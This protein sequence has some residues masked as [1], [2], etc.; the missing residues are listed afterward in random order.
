VHGVTELVDAI[1]QLLERSRSVLR[2]SA[3]WNA[4]YEIIHA[5]LALGPE[6][7]IRDAENSRDIT[8]AEYFCRGGPYLGQP[9]YAENQG[10]VWFA[11]GK[12]LVEIETHPNQFL[13]YFAQMGL[14]RDFP[15]QT[16][17]KTFTI[18][19]LVATAK[20]QFDPA[21]DATWTL[22]TLLEYGDA[23]EKWSNQF[24]QVFQ[25]TDL[26]PSVVAEL[27]GTQRVCGGTHA[28]LALAISRRRLASNE[29][30]SEAVLQVISS[31][32][33]TELQDVRQSQASDGG[34]AASWAADVTQDELGAKL[35]ATG[36]CLEWILLTLPP[37]ELSSPWVV[38]AVGFLADALSSTNDGSRR[39]PAHYHALHALRMYKETVST[40]ALCGTTRGDI[41][42]WN[43]N[44]LWS[45]QP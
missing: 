30:S 10:D 39:V 21:E 7:V 32:L 40:Y 24:G 38:R 11:R 14:P 45:F 26:V 19:D 35:Y 31:R 44:S 1:S 25:V 6:A 18:A 42:R 43:S 15:I 5:G 33:N 2:L 13:A 17:N 41:A 23:N 4:P 3:R 29:R 8:I 9:L 20:R 28:L 37:E 27:D 36:H 16:D 22:I 34:F 12:H